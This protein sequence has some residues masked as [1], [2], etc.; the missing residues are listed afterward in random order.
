LGGTVTRELFGL[1][2]ETIINAVAKVTADLEY[3]C[4]LVEKADPEFLICDAVAYSVAVVALSNQLDFLVEDLTK[5]DLSEDEIYVK[6]SKEEV[7]MLDNYNTRVEEALQSLEEVC[8]ISLQS[9]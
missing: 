8:G 5:N 3:L 2:V 4:S 1:K 9:N 7:L 6:L